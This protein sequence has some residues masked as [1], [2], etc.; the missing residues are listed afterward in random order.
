[1]SMFLI[2]A[3]IYLI[4]HSGGI[5]GFVDIMVKK[6]GI[7]K[8]KK[9]AAFFTWLLGIVV[10]TSGSLSCMVTGSVSRPLNDTMKVSH[11]KAA[12]LVH[13]TST[14]WCVLF[15]LSGWL[16]AMTGYLTSGGI[17][18]GEAISTLLRSIPLN[19]Y[20]IIAIIFSML[21]TFLPLDFGPMKKAELR[22]DTTGEL[23]DPHS[24]VIDEEPAAAV[25]RDVK[26]RMKNMP[27]PDADDGR[28]HTRRPHR[29]RR[30]QPDRRQRNAVAALGLHDLRLR[31][32]R[33]VPRRKIYNLERL[34]G[35]MLKGMATMLPIACILLL[36]L[37]MGTLV[38]QL[39]TGN[40][41]SSIFMSALVPELLPLLTF[42]ISMML[43]FATGT[44]MGTM[45]IMSVIALPMAINMGMDVPLVAGA[46]F[47]GSIFGDHVSPISDTTIM[48]C[49]TTGCKHHRPRQD[50]AP[51]RRR[52]RAR[53]DG[54]LRGAGV[55]N[56]I[57]DCKAQKTGGFEELRPVPAGFFVFG[58]VTVLSSFRLKNQAAARFLQPLQGRH[59]RWRANVRVGHT[60][61]G[62]AD[63][64]CGSNSAG[65]VAD[66]SGD[67]ADARFALFVVEGEGR[68]GAPLQARASAVRTPSRCVSV[69]RTGR[70]LS[71]YSFISASGSSMSISLPA[72]VQ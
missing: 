18:E 5:D 23:D 21:S 52:L 4:E 69:Y 39:D 27:R 53:L 61:Y 28:R 11:E 24:A 48:S 1:M 66:R 17:S 3:L 16:A 20:C 2:G 55:C 72:P 67:A 57:A 9:S 51:I 26:P 32:S 56:L 38:K 63:A 49:A 60:H 43:S 25:K 22:A 45:A 42:I 54:A 58:Q 71:R 64:D 46:L 47:G 15:P 40:Y 59:G 6:K 31:D 29:H 68:G 50:A 34:V 37:T 65:V 7:I 8:S 62:A 35:E 44:S 30:R 41:L 13:T 12:F 19:F 10:F 70:A 36:G 33:H 14:P